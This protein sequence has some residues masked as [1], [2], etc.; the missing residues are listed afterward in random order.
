MPSRYIS[1][2]AP[3]TSIA[4]DLVFNETP[5]G[6]IDGL[7]DVFTLNFPPNPAN[8]LMLFKDGML[9]QQGSGND[10]TITG[11]TITFEPDN[12]PQSY[13]IL[14]ATYQK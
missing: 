9:Q 8:A 14:L 11:V 12:I 10:Y 2:S 5:V 7:N 13:S 4:S 6:I 3:G 1:Y